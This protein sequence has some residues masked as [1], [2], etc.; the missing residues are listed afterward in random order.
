MFVQIHVLSSLPPHLPNRD[1]S[2]LAKRSYLGGIERQRISSQ[3]SKRVLRKAEGLVTTDSDGRIVADGMRELADRLGLGL[4]VRSAVIGPRVLLPAL[5]AADLPE[6]A[7]AAW[8]EAVMALWRKE[9]AAKQDADTDDEGD[10]DAADAERAAPLVVGEQEIAL[11]VDVVRA[12][13]D[14]GLE[15]AELRDLLTKGKIEDTT[16]VLDAD[17]KPVLDKKGK[18][19]TKKAPRK[20]ADAVA[21]A[22]AA[23]HAARTNAG[24][25]GALFGR[26]A[27]GVALSTVDRAVTVGEMVSVHPIRSIPDFFSATDDHAEHRGGSHINTRELTELLGYQHLL[28]D[29][30]QV[31]RNTGC[32]WAQAADIAA[33]IGRAVAQTGPLGARRAPAQLVDMVVEVGRRQ[34]RTLAGAFEV[35]V[36]SSAEARERLAAACADSDTLM[37]HPGWRGTLREHVPDAPARA[38]S[39]RPA[40]E[41]LLAAAR[42][43]LL[44]QSPEARAA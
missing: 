11:L 40:Y 41:A 38:P 21:A 29:I 42:E 19:K 1:R 26:M 16:P 14:G 17:G 27:T 44:A 13:R 22:V 2:G 10:S 25:D 37:G 15:P 7:A 9:K 12:C 34:P 28:V 5:L 24:L 4:S 8:S 43:R 35:P 20:L 31:Q 36:A 23:L 30:R 18:P 32:T 6:P 3:C 39:A 33:W